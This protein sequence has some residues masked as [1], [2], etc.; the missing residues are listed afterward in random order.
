MDE[1]VFTL[2]ELNSLR[3]IWMQKIAETKFKLREVGKSSESVPNVEELKT[4][5]SY[6]K[7]EL[8]K[9]EMKIMANGGLQ[10][11]VS[12]EELFKLSFTR[13]FGININPNS[14]TFDNYGDFLVAIE[15]ILTDAE[16]IEL[17]KNIKE[18][19][20]SYG[21]IRIKVI[22]NST[23]LMLSKQ[24]IEKLESVGFPTED[25]LSIEVVN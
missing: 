4:D 11:K 19:V 12:R 14:D 25:I 24:Q 8:S 13:S 1:S 3:S 5:L 21:A 2:E 15:I 18:N 20:K 17:L 22:P 16:R 9:I 7:T 10:P 23:S 6:F